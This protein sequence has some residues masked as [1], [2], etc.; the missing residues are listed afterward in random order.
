MLSSIPF[1]GR[2]QNALKP[3]SG[4]RVADL[5]WL[6]YIISDDFK[7]NSLLFSNIRGLYHWKETLIFEYDLRYNLY[8]AWKKFGAA[9]DDAPGPNPSNTI[10]SEEISMQFVHSKEV[11]KKLSFLFQK[12]RNVP[13]WNKA[14]TKS[15]TSTVWFSFT[16]GYIRCNSSNC[17]EDSRVYP[18]LIGHHSVITV[19]N[20]TNSLHAHY[21]SHEWCPT[22]FNCLSLVQRKSTS[23]LSW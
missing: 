14:V 13:E 19:S 5:S 16:W 7:C 17:W 20:T 2:P 1:D 23:Y 18:I 22:V 15:D 3:W 8:Q 21:C 9:K 4:K 11:R 12:M 6:C 10:I